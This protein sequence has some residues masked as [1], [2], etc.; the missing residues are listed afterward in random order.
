MSISS[1]EK[2]LLSVDTNKEENPYNEEEA[3]KEMA[4]LL[5]YK[6]P[7]GRFKGQKLMEI[8]VEYYLWFRRKGFPP[9]KLGRY[10]QIVM[11]MK[12]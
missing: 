1:E 12:S 10:M 7:F 4:E 3:R 8:P 6:M 11:E 5:E 2:K 9:G